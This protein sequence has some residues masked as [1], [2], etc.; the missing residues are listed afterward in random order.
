[1]RIGLLWGP[2]K[3]RF[4]MSEV[5]LY[6]VKDGTVGRSWGVLDV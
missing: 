3:G 4:L 6:G 5:P 2:W 1:M